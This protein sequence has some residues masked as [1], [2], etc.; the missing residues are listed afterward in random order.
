MSDTAKGLSL[1]EFLA[2]PHDPSEGLSKEQFQKIGQAEAPEDQ[3]RTGQGLAGD[4]AA[5]LRGMQEQIPFARDIGAGATALF[6]NPLT[7]ER[8]SGDFAKSKQALE[9]RNA[10]LAEEH[11]WSYGAGE[12]AG[13]LSTLPAAEFVGAKYLGQAPNL[14]G[15][16]AQAESK[17]AKFLTPIFNSKAEAQLAAKLGTGA[18]AGAAQ[19]AVHGA[20]T[21]TGEDRLSSMTGEAIMGAPLGALGSVAG[22]AAG[23]GARKLAERYG[24]AAPLATRKSVEDLTRESKNYYKQA[25]NAGLKVRASALNDLHKK[26]TSE[27]NKFSYDPQLIEQHRGLEPALNRLA[28]VTKPLDINELDNI[29]R[30]SEPLSLD[31]TNPQGRLMANTFRREYSKFLDNLAPKDIL[32]QKGKT[33]DIINTWRTGRQVWKQKEKLNTLEKLASDAEIDAEI[34]GVGGDLANAQ[35]KQV[36]RLLKD[37]KRHRDFRWSPDEVQAM[38]EFVKGG[39]T[40]KGARLIGSLSPLHNNLL[41]KLNLLHILYNPAGGGASAAAGVAGK[42]LENKLMRSA[43][44]ELKDIIAA[45]GKSANIPKVSPMTSVQSRAV[46]VPTVT[47]PV[48]TPSASAVYAQDQDRE[49][50]ASGGRLGNRDYPAKRL[51]RVERAAKRAMDAIALDTKPLLDQPDQVIADALKLASKT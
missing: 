15:K 44:E 30:A 42:Y 11:P 16:A 27:L 24:Y 40:R 35:R 2:I 32:T 31:W 26:I 12:V 6:G 29:Y 45:G 14:L 23:A 37:I 22:E 8:A 17:A 25:E 19:G 48:L 4:T 18:A 5:F 10:A 36:G 47:S 49:E 20:G 43:G 39:I 41:G 13:A 7:G 3:P 21:G 51:T 50:R 1:E 33:S 28:S 46:G 38:E 9:A 34:R